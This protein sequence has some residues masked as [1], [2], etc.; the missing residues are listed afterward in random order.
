M[1]RLEVLP[2]GT[3]P[4]R[5]PIERHHLPE[6]SSGRYGYQVFRA[7]LRWEFGF[8]CPFCLLHEADF[9]AYGTEGSG[10]MW[11][12]HRV[13]VSHDATGTNVYKNCFYS[14]RYCNLSRRV[15]AL[16]DEQGRHLL[17]PCQHAWREAFE[18]AGDELQ[19]RAGNRDAAYTI[20]SYALN[21]PRKVA[22]RQSRRETLAEAIAVVQGFESKHA[23]LMRK[24][25]DEADPTL[26][27]LA[28]DFRAYR[29]RALQDLERFVPVPDRTDRA[30]ACTGGEP[31]ALPA[32]LQEQ[33]L[34]LDLP[35]A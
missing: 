18:L 27:V 12:E 34:D 24:A 15:A 33:I 35:D 6:D 5:I 32:V 19:A 31:P 9:L 20:E 2:L 14:C 8:S 16:I 22:L 13:P 7:C 30:C 25:I 3:A 4:W 1:P 11:I 10:L 26:V 17:D 28:R 29:D 21:E 23:H